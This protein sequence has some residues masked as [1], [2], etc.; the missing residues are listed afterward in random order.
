[1]DKDT[2]EGDE[3]VGKETVYIP[4]YLTYYEDFE[5][6]DDAEFGR[7]IRAIMAEHIT[8]ESIELSKVERVVYKQIVKDAKAAEENYKKIKEQKAKAANKKWNKATDADYMQ[9]D[10]DGCTGY[11]EGCTTMQNDA[12]GM[13]TDAQGMQNDAND[14]MDNGKRIKDK[15]EE[16]SSNEEVKKSADKSASPSSKPGKFVPPTP[17]EVNDYCLSM[18]YRVDGE[19]FVDFYAQKGWMVGKNKMKDWR[20]AVRTWV[21]RRLEDGGNYQPAYKPTNNGEA[22]FDFLNSVIEG[23]DNDTAGDSNNPQGTQGGLF[24]IL[25]PD[26][27]G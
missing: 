4:L 1:M 19:Q 3:I 12:E 22:M 20:A 21:H 6:L 14:H 18:G 26:A 27:S 25:Q 23:R 10:A 2:F 5:D 13:Q 7:V 24:G 8:G 17:D 11:A 15:G 9:T 16:T